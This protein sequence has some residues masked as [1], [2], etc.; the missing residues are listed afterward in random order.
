MRVCRVHIT[1]EQGNLSTSELL[2][3]LIDHHGY[4]GDL[5]RSLE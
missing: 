3:T 2:D 5:T 1:F 4:T